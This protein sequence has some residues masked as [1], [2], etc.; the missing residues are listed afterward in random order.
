MQMFR[1]RLQMTVRVH[2]SI[3][4][5]AQGLLLLQPSSSAG[6]ELSPGQDL[7]AEM[8]L[9]QLNDDLSSRFGVDS[10]LRQSFMPVSQSTS[11]LGRVEAK[12]CALECGA[13]SY[14]KFYPQTGQFRKGMEPE[15]ALFF[16][17][18][19]DM[20][21]DAQTPFPITVVNFL[22]VTFDWRVQEL[23]EEQRHSG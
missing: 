17:T 15:R 1:S 20:R 19:G 3:M 2:K 6:A 4:S 22:W 13:G 5:S 10:S 16:W 11:Q 14:S 21:V 7:E 9:R 23:G 8:K 12:G 18:F